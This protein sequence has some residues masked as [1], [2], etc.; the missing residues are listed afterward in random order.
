MG[1]S[2]FSNSAPYKLG[3]TRRLEFTFD[4]SGDPLTDDDSTPINAV[5]FAGSIVSWI[6]LE[7][8]GTGVAVDV[9]KTA[10]G[11]IPTALD[12][13]VGGD[14]PT[15]NGQASGAVSTWNE[16]GLAVGDVLVASLQSAGNATY[17]KLALICEEG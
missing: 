13:I 17:V 12:S 15:G 10:A 7:T 14:Y 11:N 6:L 9:W 16:T 1:F 3:G 5:D 2:R 4:G 8:D